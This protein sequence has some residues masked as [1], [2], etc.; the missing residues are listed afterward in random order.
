MGGCSLR[1]G[2]LDY[3]PFTVEG[4]LIYFPL[5]ISTPCPPRGAVPV[6]PMRYQMASQHEHE[7][8][9]PVDRSAPKAPKIISR[10]KLKGVVW[11]ACF[12]PARLVPPSLRASARHVVLGKKC[13]RPGYVTLHDPSPVMAP[14]SARLGH[15]TLVPDSH[16]GALF[17]VFKRGGNRWFAS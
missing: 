8:G 13:D 2:G 17:N 5:N 11:R 4:K 6:H 12:S 14:S 10:G 9:G 3:E 15:T 16:G 7:A 1:E